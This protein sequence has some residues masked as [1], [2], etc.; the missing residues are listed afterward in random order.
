V[1]HVGRTMDPKDAIQSYQ[2]AKVA[3]RR[4]LIDGVLPASASRR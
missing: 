1:V 3:F 4:V 2:F